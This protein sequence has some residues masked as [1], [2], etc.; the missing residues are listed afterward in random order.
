MV[1]KIEALGPGE[2]APAAKV[3]EFSIE[4]Q[5]GGVP[6]PLSALPADACVMF[7][8]AF[9]TRLSG[10]VLAGELREEIREIVSR[11]AEGFFTLH[12]AAQV[13]ADSR[14]GELSPAEHVE[15]WRKAHRAGTLRVH[16]GSGRYPLGRGEGVNASRDLLEAQ[17]FDEW[18][19]ASVGYGFPVVAP[20]AKGASFKAQARDRGPKVKRNALIDQNRPQWPSVERDLRDGSSNGLS[21]DARADEWGWWYEG[22]AKAWAE[23]RGK[24]KAQA[25]IATSPFHRMKG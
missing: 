20:A 24:I 1:R 22:D 12:E 3:P 19:R 14:P 11:Q 21:D 16:K 2:T 6:P 7:K 15:Q 5:P 18:L 25:T 23:K 8:R 17:A 4:A 13:L 9:G 10:T